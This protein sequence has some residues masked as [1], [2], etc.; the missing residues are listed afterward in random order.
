MTTRNALRQLTD[1][2]LTL[3]C[4]PSGIPEDIV[5][6][7]EMFVILLY[8]RTSTCT[9][10]DKARQKIF[11]KKSDV[12]QIP[13]TKAALEQHVKRATYQGGH[14]WGRPLLATP[15][16]PLPGLDKDKRMVCTNR[17]ANLI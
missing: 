1:T 7:I 11:A 10:I 9:D 2:M 6:I 3:S 8:D 12:K 5:H 17:I 16:L 14:T 15:A 13:P 4:A